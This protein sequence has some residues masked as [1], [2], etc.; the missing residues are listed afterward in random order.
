MFQ[1]KFIDKYRYNKRFDEY[2]E[3]TSIADDNP[4]EDTIN[5]LK[6]ENIEKSDNNDDISYDST[7]SVIE[8][9]DHF[10]QR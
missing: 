8:K 10:I 4:E 1:N 5:N 9:K 7:K 2:F 6:S 3:D